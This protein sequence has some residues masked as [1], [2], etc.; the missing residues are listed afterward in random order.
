MK[1]INI[2]ILI[3]VLGTA[4][5]FSCEDPI[6]V[7]LGPTN[8]QVNVDAWLTNRSETQTIRLRR[9]SAYFDSSPSPS[10][11]GATVQ[12]LDDRGNVFDFVEDGSTGNYL[13]TPAPGE[14][15]GEV[16]TEFGLRIDIDGKEY[17]SGTVMNRIMPIDSLV[18]EFRE[19]SFGEPEGYYAEV[20]ARD[21]LGAGDSYWIKTFKNGNFLNKPSEISIAF[22]A[23][24]TPG[25]GVDGVTF[26]SPIRSSVNRSADPADEGSEDTS[27]FAPWALGDSIRVEI[28]SIS[29]A[30]FFFLEESLTQMTLGDAALFAEPPANVPTNI[31][32]VNPTEPSD[33]AVGFFNVAAVAE[34]GYIIQ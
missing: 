34:E 25:G 33:G 24:F 12:V 6:S 17:V 4:S 32:P 21:F 28:H 16:N 9:V 5:F 1:F 30:S 14:N 7:D 20:F 15:L 18:T 19:E 8:G 27:D 3:L 13:W 10:I 11:S 31:I 26:I 29:N 22:D 2:Y 23:S